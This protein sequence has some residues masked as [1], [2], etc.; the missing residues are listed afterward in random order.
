MNTFASCPQSQ[1]FSYYP[2]SR[3]SRAVLTFAILLAALVVEPVG[4]LVTHHQSN[5]P[6]VHVQRPVSLGGE[7]LIK[8]YI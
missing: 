6:V 2:Y 3:I 8:I 1:I 7:G 5:S 4:D